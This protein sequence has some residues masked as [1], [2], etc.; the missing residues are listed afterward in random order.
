MDNSVNVRII[1]GEELLG[2]MWDS[3]DKG[4]CNLL[5]PWQQRR[6]AKVMLESKVNELKRIAEVEVLIEKLRSNDSDHLSICELSSV[7]NEND[8]CLKIEPTLNL[9]FVPTKIAKAQSARVLREEVN[10]AKAV[11]NAEQVLMTKDVKVPPESVNED[12]LYEWRDSVSK[13]SESTLQELWGRILAGEVENPGTFSIRTLNYIKNLSKTDAELITNLAPFII[14][15]RVR[16]DTCGELKAIG[17]TMNHLFY[18]EQI[19]FLTGVESGLIQ[20][21]YQSLIE[22]SYQNWLRANDKIIVLK[23]PDRTHKAFL[24]VFPVSAIGAEVLTLCN[25]KANIPH[26]EKTAKHF[27]ATG[28]EVYIADYDGIDDENNLVNFSNE[29]QITI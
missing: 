4:I 3:L 7:I 20:T 9:D 12:W 23:H 2:K 6:I 19:G 27:A 28:F 16:I 26:L 17:I 13:I 29:Y 10:V 24:K 25:Y 14:G 18:L 15:N 1:P 8:V 11:L 21:Q 5:L 22:D